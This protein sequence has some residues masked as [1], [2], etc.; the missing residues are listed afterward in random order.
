MN[1][2]LAEMFGTAMLVLIGCGAITVGGLGPV[3]GGGQA[4]APLATI[5]I[6]FAFGVT[7]MAMAYGIGPISGCHVNPAVTLG[8][9]ASGRMPT[10][11]V[12]GYV[13][14]QLIG[15]VV[16]A[17]IL[18][19]LLSGK[20]GGYDLT[21]GGLGQNGWGEGYLGGYRT[22]AAIIAEFIATFVFLVVILG[23]TQKTGG[24]PSTAGLAIGLT[25]M[26]LHLPF[27]N[28]TGLSV[29]PARS[30]GPAIFVGG[31]ALAQIWLF[32]IVPSVAGLCAGF[33]FKAKVYEA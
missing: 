25:L 31:K 13:V 33:V 23:V 30:F 32:L 8:V 22:I 20:G 17:G 15:A 9:W 24:H 16:G 2:Y 10:S 3:L 12:A 28:I 1:K 14:S 19:I 4:F 29:N 27:I 21:T 6:G 11:E 5:S 26:L 7:V 18:V